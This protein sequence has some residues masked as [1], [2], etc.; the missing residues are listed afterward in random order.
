MFN[1]L[2]VKTLTARYCQALSVLAA[3][4]VASAPLSPLA[5][6]PRSG[7]PDPNAPVL[8]VEVFRSADKTSG[9]QAADAIRTR[10]TQDVPVKQL[11]VRPKQDLTNNLESSGFPTNEALNM[12]DAKQLAQLLRADVFIIGNVARDSA[13][14]YRV[15]AQYV[16]TRDQTLIQPLGTFRVNKPDQAASQISKE[17]Q[18]AQKAFASERNCINLARQQKWDQAI[19][20]ARKGIAAYPNSTLNRICIA[21]VWQEQKAS[22]DSIIAITNDILKL[23]ARSKPALNA[24]YLALKAANRSNE[25]TDVLLRLVGADPS[26]ARLLETV[27]NELAGNGQAAKAQPFVDQ[28]VRDN[29]GDP[30][31]LQ[32]QM[33]VHQAA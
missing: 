28:L 21:N 30:N 32:L 10:I 14:G 18:A 23:D 26:N 29:P 33:R 12:N 27:V 25:A 7:T 15:D 1:A 20:E 24:Q 17:F 9:V 22:P 4:F 3:G 13:T 19:A 6:Q 5:A 8:V 31:F 2:E 11:W 16:L